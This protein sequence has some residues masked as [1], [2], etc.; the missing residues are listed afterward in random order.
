[1]NGVENCEGSSTLSQNF[2]NFRLQTL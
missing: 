1:M 2:M